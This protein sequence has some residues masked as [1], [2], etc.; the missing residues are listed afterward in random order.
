MASAR[1]DLVVLSLLLIIATNSLIAPP[2][3]AYPWIHYFESGVMSRICSAFADGLGSIIVSTGEWRGGPGWPGYIKYTYYTDGVLRVT[4]HRIESISCPE[5]IFVFDCATDAMG[6]TWILLSTAEDYYQETVSPGLLGHTESGYGYR[7]GTY[8]TDSRMHDH[9]FGYID[10]TGLVECPE[11]TAAIPDQP[12]IMR[13]DPSGRIFIIS[14]EWRHNVP[15]SL[16][17]TWG[18]PQDVPS[19]NTLALSDFITNPHLPG[20]PDFYPQ[21]APDGLVYLHHY[22]YFEGV[23]YTGVVCLD[24]DTEEWQV[25]S[26]ETNPLLDSKIEYF[27]VD[28]R[29]MRWFGTED[30]LVLFD[31]ENWARFTTHNSDLPHDRVRKIAY[32]AIDDVYYVISSCRD[33]DYYEDP[34]HRYAF[35]LFASTGDPLGEPLYQSTIPRLHRGAD[36]VWYLLARSDDDLFHVYDHTTIRDFRLCDWL[37]ISERSAWDHYIGPTARDRTFLA[38][39]RYVMIW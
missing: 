4:G 31:G 5:D 28:E 20:Y 29:N 39:S 16:Y 33:E 8:P 10:G 18:D 17:I 9:R 2:A 25:F 37:D 38:S 15:L 14:W 6:T 34:E 11:V 21:F 27:H 32:D 19:L 23:R 1:T 22:Y 13:S 3:D 26:G 7:W 35:S 12:A 24:P 30:G 36:D